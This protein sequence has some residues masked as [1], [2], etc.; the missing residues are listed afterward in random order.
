[1]AVAA[2]TDA[3]NHDKESKS[4]Q[5]S[6]KRADFYSSCLASSPPFA[7]TFLEHPLL[8]KI[9]AKLDAHKSVHTQEGNDSHSQV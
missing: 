4:H 1:M 8:D 3:D 6:V 5:L 2:Q 7:S 9:T